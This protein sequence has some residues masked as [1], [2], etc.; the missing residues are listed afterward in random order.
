MDPNLAAYAAQNREEQQEEGGLL[1]ALGK[2]ALGAG[3]L[4][5]G[6]IGARRLAQGLKTG[7]TV[8]LSSFS[9]KNV[10][11][12]AAEY[13]APKEVVP[14]SRPAPTTAIQR[15][16]EAIEF[17]RQARAE[18]P[19]G[20]RQGNLQ[21]MIKQVKV[22]DLGPTY[23]P[24]NPEEIKRDLN[25]INNVLIP[26]EQKRLPSAT[27]F[28]QE[29][30]QGQTT[31]LPSTY[32]SRTPSTF[33]EFSSDPARSLL[34][35]PELLK[36]VE[37][38]ELAE[39]MRLPEA[40]AEQ[41]RQQAQVRRAY[42]ATAQDVIDAA[43]KEQNTTQ[44]A[45]QGDFARQYLQE[46]NYAEPSMVVQQQAENPEHVEH[47]VNALNAAQDQEAA[48]AAQVAVRDVLGARDVGQI[49]AR[50]NALEVQYKNFAQ[51][52]GANPPVDA[53]MTQ[54]VQE[55]TQEPVIDQAETLVTKPKYIFQERIFEKPGM[56]LQEE[57]AKVQR[58]Q[59]PTPVVIVEGR[60]ARVGEMGRP[61]RF[62]VL[63]PGTPT[64]GTVFTGLSTPTLSADEIATKLDELQTSKEAQIQNAMARG[65]SKARAQRNVQLTESQRQALEADLPTFSSEDVMS[66]TGVKGYG[67]VEEAERF[68]EE[69]ASRSGQLKALE[70][71]GFLEEQV[72]PG[73]L[74]AQPRQVQPGVM[75][76]PASRTSYR[77]MTGRPGV[78]I[79]GEQAPGTAGTPGF[80]AG[81]VEASKVIK[82]EGEERG[83]TTPRKFIPGVDDPATQ[84]PEG[85]VYTEEAM[86]QPTQARG[87]YRR[88]GTQPPTRLEAA[89]EA[90]DI[91]RQLRLL[92]QSG[93]P[94]EAQAFLDK[95]MQER[96]I[97][98]L[99]Q[100]QPLRQKINRHGKF[101]I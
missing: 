61:G 93:R 43:R 97:S 96:G 19:Q 54:A 72:D 40:R 86:T 83:V 37:T 9:P 38:E 50:A 2:I 24:I 64:E 67:N 57:A 6:A 49:N 1:D 27:E 35:D 12:V 59:T 34:F 8:D 47:A 75:I 92:Q 70:E 10:R 11:R 66:R 39:E 31:N 91:S 13:L 32:Y 62:T 16:Q 51:R 52:T 23:S 69:Q 28:L 18:R 63:S 65:L 44:A 79:Y 25:F 87:G 84:T 26:M 95:I 58:Y 101:E 4:A 80:G 14:P 45:A 85:F 22:E 33:K 98:A 48:R 41:A 77:G 60:E 68:S 15:Q 88:Y 17:T 71:V 99:G 3:A 56:R 100:S 53:A 7:A 94:E 76:R 46:Q 55:V 29:R 74:R 81:A 20:V 36:H 5:A 42:S 89:R 21:D 82:T 30:L 73:E 78:G 90:F